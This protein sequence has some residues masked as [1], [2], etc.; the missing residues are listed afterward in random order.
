MQNSDSLNWLN[1]TFLC[2]KSTFTFIA[3]RKLD[4]WCSN[5]DKWRYKLFNQSN[6]QIKEEQNDDANA[7]NFSPLLLQGTDIFI[8]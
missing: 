3:Y 1:L 8:P 2:E 5:H 7:S 6:W 4:T